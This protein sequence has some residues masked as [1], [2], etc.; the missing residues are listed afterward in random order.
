[1]AHKGKLYK[2]WFRRDAAFNLNNFKFGYPE[3][4][5]AFN[6]NQIFSPKW[7][8][9][10]WQSVLGV[11]V[12]TDLVRKWTSDPVGGFFNNAYWSVEVTSPPA[13]KI[14]EIDF[15][16]THE[17]IVDVPLIHFIMEAQQPILD[18]GSI[19]ADRI[20]EVRWLDPDIFIE[21]NNFQFTLEAAG[22]G[23]Y[24]P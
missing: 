15:R 13:E 20:K 10:L 7:A 11:N 24:N 5:Q 6:T 18:Y 19:F 17:A 22:Y 1:M 12:S 14:T 2:L 16:M 3:A 21:L 4:F 8:V 9:A 23:I